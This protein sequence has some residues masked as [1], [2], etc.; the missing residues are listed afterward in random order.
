MLHEFHVICFIYMSDRIDWE[1]Y[2]F[3]TQMVGIQVLL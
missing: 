1:W 2:F 3:F